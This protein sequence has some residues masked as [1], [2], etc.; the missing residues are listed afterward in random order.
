[1]LQGTDP[2]PRPPR[3]CVRYTGAGLDDVH[4]GAT[5]FADEVIRSITARLTEG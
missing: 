1:M 4:A 2:A 5:S 3:R